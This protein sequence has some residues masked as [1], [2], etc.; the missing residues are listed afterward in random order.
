M[1][2]ASSTSKRLLPNISPFLCKWTPYTWFIPLSLSCAPLRTASM[3]FWPKPARN[4]SLLSDICSWFWTFAREPFSV[5]SKI[6]SN[7]LQWF[8]RRYDFG[9]CW[10]RC[11]GYWLY[12]IM[13]SIIRVTRSHGTLEYLARFFSLL[14][15]LFFLPFRLE[16]DA[17]FDAQ[18]SLCRAHACRWKVAAVKK[19]NSIRDLKMP[20]QCS[21]RFS[22]LQS[23]MFL[24]IDSLVFSI[25]LAIFSCSR[26]S[27]MFVLSIGNDWSHYG[28]ANSLNPFLYRPFVSALSLSI[29][30]N[31]YFC[32][33]Q[34][35]HNA[36]NSS[37]DMSVFTWSL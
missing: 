13:R 22:G 37:Y 32:C 35:R 19:F 25:F 30:R 10:F 33:Q 28:I 20:I 29:T 2:S 31:P 16:T 26:T 21:P 14:L 7:V 24:T 5:V 17:I 11:G 6:F 15:F 23:A 18:F 1:L 36:Q 9:V 34:S 3:Y 12:M 27:A 8:Y 4:A